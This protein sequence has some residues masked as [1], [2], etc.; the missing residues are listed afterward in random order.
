MA[1]AWHFDRQDF[2][3]CYLLATAAMVTCK[4]KQIPLKLKWKILYKFM[5]AFKGPSIVYR[6]GT[7]DSFCQIG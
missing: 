1:Y 4:T 5:L 6:T 2:L 7:Y 3:D